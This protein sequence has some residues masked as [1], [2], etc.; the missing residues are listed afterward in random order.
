MDFFEIF[1]C[2]IIAY[3]IGSFP[4]SILLSKLV[5]G[6]DIREHGRG[7]ASHAN[8][9]QILGL[10]T[11]I[12]VQV[13]DVLKGVVAARVA[14]FVHHQYGFFS[15]FEYP[16]LMMT[17]G[18]AALLGH[19][20]PVFAGYRGGK[21]YHVTLGILIAIHPLAT[22]I[23]VLCTIGIFLISRYQHLAYVAGA[24]ALSLF[25]LINGKP[26]GDYLLPMQIFTLCFSLM[27]IV[28]HRQELRGIVQGTEDKDQINFLRGK[29]HRGK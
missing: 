27:L 24:L 20:F 10:R 19:I 2:T 14:L 15:E 28:T 1:L 23:F 26:F 21:G 5:Y 12:L 13:L 22:G 11:G 6:I 7:N 16:I 4:S 8:V 29:I 17:F 18:L 3:L 25:V 9:H